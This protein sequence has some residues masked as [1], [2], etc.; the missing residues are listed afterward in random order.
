MQSGLVDYDDKGLEKNYTN[1]PNFEL[2]KPVDYFDIMENH[3]KFKFKPG[4]G[5]YY[6]SIGYILLQYT[7]ASLQGAKTWSDYD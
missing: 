4:H 6:S 2:S 1:I 5:Y 3:G 7:L